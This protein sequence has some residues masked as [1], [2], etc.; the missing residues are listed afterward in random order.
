[1]NVGEIRARHYAS[2]QPT[3]L[4][5]QDGIVT[6]IEPL[7]SA[8]E[9]NL[10]LAPTLV[11]LQVN[12]FAGVDFQQDSLTSELLLTA[13]RALRAAGCPRFLLTLVTDAWPKLTARLRWLR[14]LRSQSA[15]LQQAI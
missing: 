1:M 10:W 14:M 4:R 13:A 11:D 8:P 3:S 15:E 9:E 6:Q 5:W 12:G 7:S 2:G